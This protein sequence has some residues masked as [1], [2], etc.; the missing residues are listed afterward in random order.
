MTATCL[1]TVIGGKQWHG[2]VVGGKHG[3]V[4]VI[5]GKQGHAPVKYLGSN[6]SSIIMSA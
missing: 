2:P 5:G 6:K 1:E 4:P 3:H